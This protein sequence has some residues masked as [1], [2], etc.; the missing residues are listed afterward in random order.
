MG[1]WWRGGCSAGMGLCL[2]VWGSQGAGVGAENWQV[3]SVAGAGRCCCCP[4]GP[5]CSRGPEL[6]L[7]YPPSPSGSVGRHCRCSHGCGIGLAGLAASVDL[8]GAGLRRPVGWMS[9]GRLV[10]L[11]VVRGLRF[12]H[13]VISCAREVE[14][15][16]LDEVIIDNE[17]I[18]YASLAA[19]VTATLM[20]FHRPKW[21]RQDPPGAFR[22]SAVR[23]GELHPE[24]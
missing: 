9:L 19:E 23:A 17:R 12:R 14:G 8:A 2:V 18:K 16:I 22:A 3:G 6:P 21:S 11:V 15:S 7:A 5:C 20:A 10:Q 4:R 13:L 1:S 24:V